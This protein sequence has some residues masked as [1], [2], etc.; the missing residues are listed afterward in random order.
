MPMT[1][2]YNTLKKKYPVLFDPWLK[3]MGLTPQIDELQ[4]C[5]RTEDIPLVNE[6]VDECN[7]REEKRATKIKQQQAIAG[8]PAY[9]SFYNELFRQQFSF[10]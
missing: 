10:W 5:V 3:S 9:P 4:F 8:T 7:Q 1:K 2:V 6:Y